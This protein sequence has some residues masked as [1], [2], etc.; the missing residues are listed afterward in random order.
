MSEKIINVIKITIAFSIMTVS[1][2]LSLFFR[3]LSFGLLLRFNRTVFIPNAC[4][5]ILWFLGIQIDNRIKDNLNLNN[6]FI[7]FNHNSYL[8]G[9]VLM[10]LGVANARVLISYK[11]VHYIPATLI[12]LGIGGLYVPMKKHPKWR[13]HFFKRLSTKLTKEGMGFMGSSEGVHVYTHEINPFNRGVYHTAMLCK[14]P[15]YALFIH[16]PRKSNPMATFK[17]FKRGTVLID[18]VGVFETKDWN[19]DD[20]DLHI[21]IIRQQYI[22]KDIEIKARYGI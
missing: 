22:S 21:E 9:F 3:I 17:P 14:L 2:I 6:Y 16:T 11:L 19:L 18:C 1:G 15:V 7:T 4:K 10:S 20:L 5:L 8:D 12:V 13:L